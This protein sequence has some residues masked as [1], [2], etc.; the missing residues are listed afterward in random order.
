MMVGLGM[1]RLGMVRLGWVRSKRS[2]RRQTS[3]D[4]KKTPPER[5]QCHVDREE[6]EILRGVTGCFVF[7]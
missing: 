1:V 3:D 2:K 5:G 4:Q 7:I 6:V